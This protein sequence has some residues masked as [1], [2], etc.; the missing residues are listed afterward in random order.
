M[1]CLPEGKS[2]K[3]NTNSINP[4]VLFT[5]FLSRQSSIFTFFGSSRVICYSQEQN[6]LYSFQNPFYF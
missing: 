5:L 2:G 4:E 1:R 3:H 6:D